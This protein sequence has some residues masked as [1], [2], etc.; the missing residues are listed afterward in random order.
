MLFRC[1]FDKNTARTTPAQHI[2]RRLNE[3]PANHA[4]CQIGL[5]AR[6]AQRF[7]PSTQRTGPQRRAACWEVA[8]QFG[9]QPDAVSASPA[10]R[11]RQTVEGLATTLNLPTNT[12]SFHESLYLALPQTL[13]LAAATFPDSVQTGP[14]IAHNP[15]LEEWVAQLTGARVE[16]PTA[17]LVTI[18]L[19][20]FSW[21]EI[22]QT[23]G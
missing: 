21:T 3:A 10:L 12:L 17:G 16:L 19:G 2:P 7:R 9:P 14:L 11:A 20:C 4:P 8:Q 13:A 23:Y 18:Q 6:R 15:G 22:E 1:N 5:P